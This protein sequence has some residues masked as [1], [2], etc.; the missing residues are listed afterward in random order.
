[1]PEVL[2]DGVTGFIV[3]DEVAAVAAV[4]RAVT[5]NRTLIRT[6]FEVRF[7]AQRMV[8]EYVSIYHRLI[9]ATKIPRALHKVSS[10]AMIDDLPSTPVR[11]SV[12]AD[13]DKKL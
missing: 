10:G 9:A 1:M 8:E 7:S 12:G 11:T 3:S 2:E 13:E 5:L 4:Q 6:R